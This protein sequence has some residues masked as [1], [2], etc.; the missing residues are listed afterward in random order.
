MHKNR[1]NPV[2]EKEPG[3]HKNLDSTQKITDR[4][5]KRR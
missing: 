4:R 1:R 5:K 2:K 3:K